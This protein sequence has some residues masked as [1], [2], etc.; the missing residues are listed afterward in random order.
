MQ[1]YLTE[2]DPFYPQ[3]ALFWLL[4]TPTKVYTMVV[5]EKRNDGNVTQN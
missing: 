1:F 3:R 5:Y 4:T 2:L